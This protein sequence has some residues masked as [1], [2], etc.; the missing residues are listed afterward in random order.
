[1]S[2]GTIKWGYSYVPERLAGQLEADTAEAEGSTL[3]WVIR[4]VGPVTTGAGAAGAEPAGAEPA[5]AEPAG[6]LGA[7]QPPEQ[8]VMV[9]TLVLVTVSSE[10][11][12]GA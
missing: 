6:A 7:W 3:V 4:V 5:G 2:T 1:M 11:G 12:A 10:A 9:S 8:L